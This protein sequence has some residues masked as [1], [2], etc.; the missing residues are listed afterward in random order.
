MAGGQRPRMAIV[1][2]D[3]LAELGL[4]QLL[5]ELMPM[6]E[7]ESFDSLDALL[8]ADADA[9]F[10]YFVVQSV[11]MAH[12]QWFLD[13]AHKTI[14][15][16]PSRDVATQPAGFHCLCTH[17]SEEQLAKSLLQLV[18]HAHSHG[19]NL[20]KDVVAAAARPAT[21]PK[22]LS[23]REIEVLS[24]IVRGL[25]NK[26]IADRLNI[27]LTTVITHR[28]NIM[29]KLGVRSVSALTIYAVMH[30]YVDINNI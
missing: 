8:Q 25:I 10:H 20:P 26:E 12:R 3:T 1:S 9:F 22:V 5:Q 4:K 30:G 29:E 24:L 16:T 7:I 27:G 18:S 21:Q 28:K 23:D 15:L 17:V 11:V 6:L 14:V 13:H 2:P 19:R